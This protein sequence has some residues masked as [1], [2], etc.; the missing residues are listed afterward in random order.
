MF[1]VCKGESFNH[2]P[3]KY[4]STHS[5]TDPQPQVDSLRLNLHDLPLGPPTHRIA[6]A[7]AAT[8]TAGPVRRRGVGVVGS[9]RLLVTSR[10]CCWIIFISCTRVQTL[11]ASQLLVDRLRQL[12]IGIVRELLWTCGQWVVARL[13][14]P[15]PALK[16]RLRLQAPGTGL[17][18]NALTARGLA[19]AGILLSARFSSSHQVQ[20]HEE[21]QQDEFAAMCIGKCHFARSVR[22]YHC[23]TVVCLKEISGDSN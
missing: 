2:C 17:C 11:S 16:V 3:T 13:E 6:T 22:L 19:R 9:T 1:L 20:R 8:A 10:R 14:T 18:L 21:G 5:L 4:N 12:R 15:L 7:A 23:A